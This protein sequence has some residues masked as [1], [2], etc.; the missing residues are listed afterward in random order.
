M[1]G[2]K[3]GFNAR[4]STDDHAPALQLTVALPTLLQQS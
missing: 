4:I 1:P 3:Y 2:M